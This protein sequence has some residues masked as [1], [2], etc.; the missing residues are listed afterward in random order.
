MVWRRPGK[1]LS[2]PLMVSLLT[3]ICVTR[4]Q[5]V[6]IMSCC[7]TLPQRVNRY[8]CTHVW[9]C[10]VL[11]YNIR[12]FCAKWIVKRLHRVICGV[13]IETMW[14]AWPEKYTYRFAVLCI[15]LVI[16]WIDSADPF[17]HIL[18]SC[19]TVTGAILRLPQC[20]GSTL[21]AVSL[22]LMTSQFQDIVNHK[23]K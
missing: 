21:G 14:T 7:L 20:Q 12:H 22:R 9:V 8:T 17:T 3:G 11:I 13:I 4:P 1:P 23:E 16:S 2:E 5:W 19:L 6:K 10:C 18:H 15:V